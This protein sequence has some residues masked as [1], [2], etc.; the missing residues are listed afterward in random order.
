MHPTAL[1]QLVLTNLRAQILVANKT[2]TMK[3][4]LVATFLFGSLQ[5]ASLANGVS[6][7][8]TM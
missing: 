4:S 3:F 5:Q 6:S 7:T 2:D 8:L 1:S